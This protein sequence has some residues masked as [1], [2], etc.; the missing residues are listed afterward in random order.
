MNFGFIISRHVN[1]EKTNL[2]WNTC[3][4]CLRRV[5]PLKPIVVIDDN[6][7]INFVKQIHSYTDNITIVKSEF[8]KRGELLPFYYFLRDKYFENAIIIHD[9]VFFRKRI[10]FEKLIANNI[11]VMPIWNFLKDTL[12]QRD[13]LNTIKY[14]RNKNEIMKMIDTS[15][16]MRLIRQ[17]RN[18]T[19]W[20]G[21]FGVQCFIN[22]NFLNHLQAKY[23]ICGLLFTIK[24]REDRMILERLFG[25]LFFLEYPMMQSRALLGN[26][27][28]YCKW[29]LTYDDFLA[30][31]NL[32][33]VKV[34]TGR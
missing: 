24:S 15:V 18:S 2:Y 10:S 28:S 29:G 22:Y 8:P 9:S 31:T 4:T 20:F 19:E 3:I 7:D 32:P 6:S 27:H 33:I 1:S 21:C 17:R 23:N 26:I 16:D 34:W 25:I 30:G 12:N 11:K 5:Y 14:M 13:F